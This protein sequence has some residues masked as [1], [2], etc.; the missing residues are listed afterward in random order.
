VVGNPLKQTRIATVDDASSISGMSPAYRTTL[1]VAGYSGRA[2]GTGTTLR[3]WLAQLCG[4]IPSL[5]NARA[6]TSW[7]VASAAC[8]ALALADLLLTAML[9]SA[10]FQVWRDSFMQ[11]CI[12]GKL[13]NPCSLCRMVVSPLCWC[14]RE[15]QF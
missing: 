3:R 9:L 2:G 14:H 13:V 5:K 6:V 4:F 10:L 7:E 15:S 12:V 8:T 11:A 1:G